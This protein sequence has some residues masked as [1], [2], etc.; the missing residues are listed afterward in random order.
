MHTHQ[1]KGGGGGIVGRSERRR[2]TSNLRPPPSHHPTPHRK[3]PT[4]LSCSLIVIHPTHPH[5]CGSTCSPRLNFSHGCPP[6]PPLHPT[7]PDAPHLHPTSPQTPLSPPHQL[8]P[9]TGP[10]HLIPSPHQPLPPTGPNASSST[11]PD[12]RLGQAREDHSGYP[13][14]RALHIQRLLLHWGLATHPPLPAHKPQGACG[15]EG[16]GTWV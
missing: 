5:T 14:H 6:T 1:G 11:A 16:T 8:T 2:A 4:L 3:V 9:P 15:G 13:A 7:S 12:V 10:H